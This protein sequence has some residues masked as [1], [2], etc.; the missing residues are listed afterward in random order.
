MK[1]LSVVGWR[2]RSLLEDH[3]AVVEDWPEMAYVTPGF[4]GSR[5]GGSTTAAW[6]V[7]KLLREP[8]Y[9]AEPHERPDVAS[10]SRAVTPRLDGNTWLVGR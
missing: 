9:L 3:Y 5:T 4:G 2:D 10:L 8:G 1:M 6:A 7:M